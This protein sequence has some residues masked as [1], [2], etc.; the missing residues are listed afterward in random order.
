MG[1]VITADEV[2]RP[3]VDEIMKY[4]KVKDGTW[5]GDF[6]RTFLEFRLQVLRTPEIL[7]AYEADHADSL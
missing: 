2:V 1:M 6:A 5:D 4:F 3:V 7:K